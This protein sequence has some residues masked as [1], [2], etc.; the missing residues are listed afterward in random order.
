MAR[1]RCLDRQNDGTK[2]YAGQTVLVADRPFSVA[3]DLE[4]TEAEGKAFWPICDKYVKD[5]QE[6]G[7]RGASIVDDFARNYA[8]HDRRQ[9]KRSSG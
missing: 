1:T 2:R 8:G 7:V 9:S 6:I 5:L 4:L 3:S